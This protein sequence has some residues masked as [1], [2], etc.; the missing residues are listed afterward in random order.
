MSVLG[1]KTWADQVLCRR[2]SRSIFAAGKVLQYNDALLWQIKCFKE[3][4]R[5][6]IV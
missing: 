3:M 1:S 4:D 6:E 2:R 5:K